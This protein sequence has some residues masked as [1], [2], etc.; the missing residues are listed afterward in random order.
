MKKAHVTLFALL[1]AGA[2]VLGAV[3]V[4]RTTNLGRAARHT[5]DAA[6]AARTKQLG[7]Y[8]AKLQKELKAKPPALPPVPKPARTPAPGPA[9]APAP[10]QAPRIIYHRPPPVVT[11]IHTHGGDDA[12]HESDGGGGGDD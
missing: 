9:A 1:I 10:P 4:T 6:I 11:V 3:A 12:S 2:T 7:T 5:N 8:A